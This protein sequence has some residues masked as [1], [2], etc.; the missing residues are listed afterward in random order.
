MRLI[1]QAFE[2]AKKEI[3]VHEGDNNPKILQYLH[4]VDLDESRSEEHTSELQS[5]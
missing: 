3:G 5:H 2:F 4:S 1:E